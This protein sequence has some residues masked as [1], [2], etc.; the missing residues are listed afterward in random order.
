[1]QNFS[2]YQILFRAGSGSGSGSGSGFFQMSDLSNPSKR[3]NRRNKGRKRG[4]GG[5]FWGREKS[6]KGRE[7]TIKWP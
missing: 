5:K 2:F 4:C 6:Q 1:M 3:V 7:F